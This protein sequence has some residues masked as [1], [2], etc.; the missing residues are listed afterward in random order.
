M[1]IFS[2]FFVLAFAVSAT[3]PGPRFLGPPVLER[4]PGGAL[5]WSTHVSCDDPV[6]LLGAHI[7]FESDGDLDGVGDTVADSGI[8]RA[9]RFPTALS[10]ADCNDAS[11]EVRRPLP[12]A[13]FSPSVVLRAELR[14]RRAAERTGDQ[15]PDS[16]IDVDFQ[17]TGGPGSLL[18]LDRFCARPKNGEPEWVEIRN[19]STLTTGLAKV[20]LEGRALAGALEPAE[21]R[22]AHAAADS[23]AMRTWRPGARLFGLSSWPGLRNTGDTVRLTFDAAGTNH[24]VRR[25]LLDSLVYAA[26]GPGLGILTGRGAREECASAPTEE[27]GAA[28]FGYGLEVSSGLWKRRTSN[29]EIRVMAPVGGLWNLSLFD[30]DG[31]EVCRLARRSTGSRT[32]VLSPRDCSGASAAT[33]SLLIFLRP[34]Q[35][36]FIRRLLRIEP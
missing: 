2:A 9:L 31:L 3:F 33:T 26:S 10:P 34:V 7:V 35:A 18:A 14:V 8:V 19:V 17:V 16:T 13:L 32:V 36:P 12:K 5:E 6:A 24:S 22:V 25:V 20:M 23:A 27:S 4:L 21:A 1:K 11:I 29:L 28:A 15:S 30:L